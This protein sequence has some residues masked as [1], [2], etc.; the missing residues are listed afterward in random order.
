MITRRTFT[1]ASILALS[2]LY[3]PAIGQS[4]QKSLRDQIKENLSTLKTIIDQEA[5]PDYHDPNKSGNPLYIIHNPNFLLAPNFKLKE[6]ATSGGKLLP[7]ARIDEDLVVVLQTL[8]NDLNQPVI[9][10][11]AYRS[12]SGNKAVNGSL[13]SRHLSGDAADIYVKG[14]SPLAIMRQIE[15]LFGENIS[16]HAYKDGHV[17]LDLRG[18]KARW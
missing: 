4:Q 13:K 10:S 7:Y 12:A 2:S 6:F 18:Y 17:H 14:M 11:S 3:F 15:E 16:L 8:R 9:I 1:K 5:G